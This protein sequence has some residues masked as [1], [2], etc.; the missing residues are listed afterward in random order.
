MAF[1][2]AALVD[3]L[4]PSLEGDAS[5]QASDEQDKL[6]TE[7][8]RIARAAK[9]LPSDEELLKEHL[10]S[11]EQLLEREQSRRSGV[12]ARLLNMAGLVSIAG[13]VVLGALFSLAS[14][15]IPLD[16]GWVRITLTIGCLYLAVQLV[17][18]L[19]ASVKGLQATGYH[20]DQPHAILP[21]KG[22][23]QTV[24]LRQ[25]VQHVLDRVAENRSVNNKK[26]DQL[27][28]A[29]CAM[30]NFL[31]GLLL[32][33]IAA[34][35]AAL[36]RLPP[37]LVSHTLATSASLGVPIALISGGMCMAALGL[38]LLAVGG[39]SARRVFGLVMA[40]SGLGIG[41]MGSGKLD[42]AL[43]EADRLS[44]DLR[45]EG[46]S[47]SIAH[48]QQAVI[49]RVVTIGPFPD[50]D[51][52]LSREQVAQCVESAIAQYKSLSI[53]GWEV[54]GRI[55]KRS[56]I[57][58]QA[59]LYRS[60]QALAMFRANWVVQQILASQLSFDFEH[61]VITLGEIRGVDT[62]VG[63]DDLQSKH[64][65]DIYAMLRSESGEVEIADLPDPVVCSPTKVHE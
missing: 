23:Q 8:R 18:A 25:R 22:L 39:T 35:V 3:L 64:A 42:A 48:P 28:L 16:S 10:K 12:E 38:G 63:F 36:M 6:N 62:E 34:C 2:V 31:W 50:G 19:H 21:R 17:A 5:R 20:E 45:F 41:A 52:S 44:G 1:T 47:N 60:N 11:S 9:N 26:L 61:T 27:N 59:A 46:R 37:F 33:A 65:V 56:A 57:E 29:H 32:V 7:K 24:F 51:Q 49:R 43:L 30:K 55:D 58:E 4:W 15:K 53:G 13:T 14:E 54:V 40:V